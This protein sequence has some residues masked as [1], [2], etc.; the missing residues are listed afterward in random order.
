[1]AERKAGKPR[2][3]PF[4]KGH[5]RKG[6]RAKGTPNRFTTSAKEAF[7][8][9]FDE[10]GGPEGL[11][12]WARTNPTEFY[13]LFARLIPQDVHHSGNLTFAGLTPVYGDTDT[14]DVPAPA[15]SSTTRH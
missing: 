9:A 5:P 3:R 10:L 6:G 7:Q 11:K 15:E 12:K 4:E 8:I 1:M 13:K 2:G 14:T